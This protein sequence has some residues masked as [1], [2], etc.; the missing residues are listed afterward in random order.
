VS[1]SVVIFSWGVLSFILTT[2]FVVFA[3]A[4]MT[5][6]WLP[7]YPRAKTIELI[8]VVMNPRVLP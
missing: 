3:I 1:F 8:S 7:F 4:M 6:F 2:F 5:L